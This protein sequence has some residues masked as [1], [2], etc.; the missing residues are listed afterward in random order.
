MQ[1]VTLAEV[2]IFRPSSK[3]GGIR[4]IFVKLVVIHF[5]VAT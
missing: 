3:N 2:S 4:V 1:S 5:F